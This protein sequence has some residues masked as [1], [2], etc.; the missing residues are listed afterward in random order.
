MFNKLVISTN[1]KR[2]KRI[3]RF[4]CG[5]AVIYAA[6]TTGV[7]A[8][9]V[10]VSNPRL[11]DGG[12]RAMTLLTPPPPPAPASVAPHQE[13]APFHPA[14]APDPRNPAPLDDVIK[15]P[16]PTIPQVNAPSVEGDPHAVGGIE[17]VNGGPGVGVPGA[18]L[19]I[20]DPTPPPRAVEPPHPAPV[21]PVD[22]SHPLRLPSKVLQ[23]KA[24]ERHKPDYP[25][26]ARQ[27]RLEGSVS[28]EVV[29]GPDGRV[30]AARAVNGHPLLISAAVQ[31]AALWRFQPTLLNEVPVR[32]TGVIVFNFSLQ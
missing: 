24:L 15:A 9:T 5:T 4:F 20:G 29:I 26:L 18:A 1:E 25:A 2:K 22:T 12:E 11:A 32:V 7:L 19:N 6:V 23:G 14:A 28:V 13:A 8:L 31:A 3:A 30:E 27:I 21:A 10:A 16:V 17:G